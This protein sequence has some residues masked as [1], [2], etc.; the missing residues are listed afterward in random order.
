MIRDHVLAISTILALT[1][2]SGVAQ[3]GPKDP[4]W[5]NDTRHQQAE[6]DWRSAYARQ[7]GLPPA[8]IAP[9]DRSGCRYQGG[10]KSPATCSR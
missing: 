2:L 8:P 10:P 5:P 4:N 3:A 9:A 7:G 1:A 6:A